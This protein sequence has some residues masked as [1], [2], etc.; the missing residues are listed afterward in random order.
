LFLR[1][2]EPEEH[3]G[4]TFDL[5]DELTVGRAPG[6]G[7]STPEDIYASTLHARLFRHHDQVWVE[8]LGSTNGTYL[9]SERIAQAQ[10]LAK[11]DVLQIGST[12]FEVAR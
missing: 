9:N 8:D 10:R 3:Q 1:V 7:I 2:V 5:S 11:G 12:V 6:C 4:E